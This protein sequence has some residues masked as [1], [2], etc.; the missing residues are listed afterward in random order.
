[1][2]RFTDWY[3]A[4]AYAQMNANAT[5]L[6]MGIRKATEYGKVGFNVGFIPKPKF[7]FGSDYTC[8]AVEPER[9]P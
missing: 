2:K 8:E 1:M 6:S 4:H 3:E 5:G 9:N 7:R